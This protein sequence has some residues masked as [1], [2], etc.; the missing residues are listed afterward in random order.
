MT[1][2]LHNHTDV[3]TVTP[4]TSRIQSKQTGTANSAVSGM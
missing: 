4:M 3:C 1:L 2:R